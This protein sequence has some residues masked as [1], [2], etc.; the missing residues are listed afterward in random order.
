MSADETPYTIEETEAGFRVLSPD[1]YPVLECR[2]RHSADHYVE[3]LSRAYRNGYKA[4]YR[5]AKKV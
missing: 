4:G 3:L 2:D 1:G 5:A